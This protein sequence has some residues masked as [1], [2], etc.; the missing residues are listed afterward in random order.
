VRRLAALLVLPA[1]VLTGCGSDGG[2]KAS[3][4]ASPSASASA[5]AVPTPVSS[6]SPMPGVS[7]AAG[8]KATI[9]LPSGQPSGRFVVST[10][11]EGS[12]ATVKKSDFVAIDYTAKDWTTGKDIPSSYDTGQKPQLYQAGSGQLIPAFDRSVVG[13]KV[14]SRVLVVAPPAAAFG[15]NGSSALGVGADDTLVFVVDVL[16]AVPQDATLSGTPIPAPADLPQVQDN[17]KAAPTVTVPKGDEPPTTLKTAVLVKGS[18]PQVKS[19][20]TIVAQYTGVLWS[21][22][23]TFDSSWKHGGAT[24]MQ[25]GAG[26]VIKGWDQGL[27]GQTVGSRVL[28]VIPPSLAYGEK[29]QDSIPAKSTLVFVID[30]LDAV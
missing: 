6:A 25:I 9:A 21:N 16:R 24:A 4:S 3:S 20:Q 10:V 22:G 18:G 1:L 2:S 12:G 23:S 17:G 26:Q 5:T 15:T 7:G 14:G 13:R 27:V 11:T 19:G 28:L 8:A 29:A 30:I